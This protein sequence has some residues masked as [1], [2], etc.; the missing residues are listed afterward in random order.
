MMNDISCML[1]A[2]LAQVAAFVLPTFL[3]ARRLIP[4]QPWPCSVLLAT[5]MGIGSQALLGTLWGHLVGHDAAWE[6]ML[7]MAL[8]LIA[9]VFALRH[10]TAHA[11]VRQ[12][13]APMSAGQSL[14]LAAILLAGLALRA[15]HP[16]Q[17]LALGQSDAYSHLQ[18]ILNIVDY[19]KT[20]NPIYPPGHAWVMAL[21]SLMFNLDPYVLARFGGAFFGAILI[22]GVHVLTLHMGR[23]V[24]AAFAAAFL[25]SCFPAF[26]LLHK[27]SVGVFANQMGLALI[28][29]IFIF[30]IAWVRNACGWNMPAALLAFSL[31]AMGITSSIMLI[32]V[33]L[34]L[35]AERF[36]ALATA[37]RRA[38]PTL[39]RLGVIMIPMAAFLAFHIAQSRHGHAK[40]INISLHAFLPAHSSHGQVAPDVPKQAKH[41]L[42]TPAQAALAVRDFLTVKRLGYHNF[43]MNGASFVILAA[44]AICAAAGL[45]KRSEALVLL[46]LWGSL[47][48]VQALT[49]ALQFT[50]Y[51]REGWSLLIAF[52][53]LAGL[54]FAI[55]YDA[56]GR[57]RLTRRLTASA[58]VASVV[59]AFLHPP[60]HKFFTCATEDDMV[61]WTRRLTA[62]FHPSGHWP[63]DATPHDALPD[64]L[65][66][67]SPSQQPVLVTP[68]TAGWGSGQ[69]ELVSVIGRGMSVLLFA[70]TDDVPTML[71]PKRTYIILIEN[72]SDGNS[73]GR[74]ELDLMRSLQPA[75][76]KYYVEARH[77][78][79]A[80]VQNMDTFLASDIARG[81]WD[82]ARTN[83]TPFLSAVV[84]N[85]R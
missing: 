81:N 34:L 4:G 68:R 38:W 62:A 41:H 50:S 42:S 11:H 74:M 69:G 64:A 5:V 33:I 63:H 53:V 22:L 39:L 12:I 65:Q 18:F 70:A 6:A 17:H 43:A 55:C 25:A 72:M 75:L 35:F 78:Q 47:T 77:R 15:V 10:E 76:V 13:S 60:E 24:T 84:L 36:I 52:T 54:I 83:L 80:A 30:H 49:G 48:S 9:T 66:T 27:T 67:V 1:V 2:W 51:Q 37:G 82:I 21:P 59:W 71:K 29:V 56:F 31:A 8:W 40:A 85:P 20:Q 23:S 19:G 44:F 58:V 3:A 73:A 14:A 26:N 28:P 57:F 45:R 32:H 16:L 46:G 79:Q 7:W 61:R